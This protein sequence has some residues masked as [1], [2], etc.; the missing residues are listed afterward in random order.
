MKLTVAAKEIVAAGMTLHAGH[1]LN[2]QNA[3]AV[4]DIPHM[5][6]LN[7]GHSIVARAIM[8]GFQQAVREMKQLIQ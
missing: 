6:E 1:G 4:A 2:Y 5:D 8:V 7:I 3:R